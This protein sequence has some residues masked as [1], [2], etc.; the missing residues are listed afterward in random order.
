MGDLVA[1]EVDEDDIKVTSSNYYD[2]MGIDE[3]KVKLLQ[4]F[5]VQ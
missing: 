1:T 3:N 4:E 2:V 5:R